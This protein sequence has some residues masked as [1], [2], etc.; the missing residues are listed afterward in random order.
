M[1]ERERKKARLPPLHHTTSI[2]DDYNLR[3]RAILDDASLPLS[4]SHSLGRTSQVGLIICGIP[5]VSNN[6][7]QAGK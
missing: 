7:G 3:W 2:D 5:A 4:L 1:L 6:G